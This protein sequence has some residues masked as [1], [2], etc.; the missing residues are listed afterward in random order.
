MEFSEL[1]RRDAT[2]STIRPPV[3]CLDLLRMNFSAGL[4]TPPSIIAGRMEPIIH[5]KSVRCSPPIHTAHPVV[6]MTNFSGARMGPAFRPN[7]E[8]DQC[9]K[10][11]SSLDR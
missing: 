8:P 7:T 10:M 1:L 9:R 3:R 4:L 11:A 2:H 6:S 5:E